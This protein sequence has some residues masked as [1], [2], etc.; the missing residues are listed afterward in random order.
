M[1]IGNFRQ[2]FKVANKDLIQWFP[3]HMGKGIRQMQQKLKMVDC[4]I[5][6][7]DARIPFSGR[8]VDF[9]HTITGVRPHILVLNKKD[10]SDESQFE[11][12]AEKIKRDEGI[13]NVLYT[14]CK[15]QRCEGT[16]RLIPLA[17]QLIINSNRFNRNNQPDYNIMIIGVPNVGKSSLTNVL[18]NRHLKMKS[19]SAVGGVA[20]ITRSVLNRIKISETP[21]I[22]MYDTPGILTPRIADTDQG[23]KLALVSCL[24]DHLVGHTVI[25]DYLL[26][27]LNKNGHFSYVEVMNLPKP[28]DSIEEVLVSCAKQLNK[29]QK[30]KKFD[31]SIVIR[32]NFDAAAIHFLK[33]FRTGSLGKLNLD[34]NYNT[35]N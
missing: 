29:T 17:K 21:K 26:Y 2:V 7:H 25:A 11:S 24:Q 3:G 8:N 23:M 14:N 12:I 19:A 4:V 32:P 13:E 18:R 31:G 22:Y 28:T 6:V 15:D 9:K 33:A 5:E 1:S 10:I 16:R 30:I 34:N 27:W 35:E 20:G